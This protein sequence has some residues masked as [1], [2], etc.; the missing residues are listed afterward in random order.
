MRESNTWANQR[1]H[2]SSSTIRTLSLDAFYEPKA[3]SASIL[4]T[5]FKNEICS[6]IRPQSY[7]YSS[8]VTWASACISS[9]LTLLILLSHE[10]MLKQ[11][12]WNSFW[13]VSNLS[14]QNTHLA[15]LAKCFWNEDTEEP[16]SARV[17]RTSSRTI[18]AIFSPSHILLHTSSAIEVLSTAKASFRVLSSLMDFFLTK[19]TNIQL[20]CSK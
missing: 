5:I 12:N 9:D 11:D 1:A 3:W 20:K 7:I 17:G 14:K 10:R 2:A 18:F 4:S 15:S 19:F 13:T 8:R 16:T 6:L